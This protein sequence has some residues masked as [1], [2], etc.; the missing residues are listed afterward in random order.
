MS[1]STSKLKAISTWGSNTIST[2]LGNNLGWGWMSLDMCWCVRGCR[3]GTARHL[4]GRRGRSWPPHSCTASTSPPPASSP[5]GWSS[6]QRQAR[7]VPKAFCLAA[8]LVHIRTTFWFWGRSSWSPLLSK[9]P[10]WLA[11]FRHSL[12]KP[13]RWRMCE[14]GD[15]V[16]RWRTVCPLI[17]PCRTDPAVFFP[18]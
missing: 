3:W 10:L 17:S 1:R 15:L 4:R 6:P 2:C 16:Q 12:F 9:L 18:C 8:S 14:K 13:E 11:H 5:P 7:Q